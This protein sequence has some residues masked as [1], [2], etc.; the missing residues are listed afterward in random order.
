MMQTIY[1]HTPPHPP[2]DNA[3]SVSWGERV[4]TG[5]IYRQVATNPREIAMNIVQFGSDWYA[6][7][8]ASVEEH[9]ASASP[10]AKMQAVAT[11]VAG[12]FIAEAI[13]EA[14]QA[15]DVSVAGAM[16][17]LALAVDRAA[18]RMEANRT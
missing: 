10:D 4:S 9:H 16:G 7:M 13:T 2:K 3:K 1:T 15:N 5:C 6:K 8:I 12:A 14:L 17:D 11:M 18:E